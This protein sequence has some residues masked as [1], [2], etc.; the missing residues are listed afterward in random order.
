MIQEAQNCAMPM[1]P[2]SDFTPSPPRWEQRIAWLVLGLMLAAAAFDALRLHPGFATYDEEGP[3]GMAQAWRE[4]GALGWHFG[5]GSVH[6]ALAAF[7]MAALGPGQ[8]SPRLPAW[9][10]VALEGPLL[11]LWARPRLGGPPCGPRWPWA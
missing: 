2:S 8:F 9:I 1:P 10:G 5:K 4:G 7:S 3:L 11:W 6:R